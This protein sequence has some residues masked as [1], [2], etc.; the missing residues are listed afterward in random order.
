MARGLTAA[1]KALLATRVR[2]PAYFVDLVLTSGTVRVWNGVGDTTVLGNT[3]KGVG[4][5]G[6]IDGIEQDRS[7]KSTSVTL[8]LVGVPGTYITSGVIAATRAVRYQGAALTIYLGFCN[9]DTGI[10]LADP[11]AIWTGFADVMTFSLGATIS[12][13]LTAEHFTSHLTR[14]NGLTMT[15]VNHNKRLGSPSPQDLFF[16]G[17]NRL[18]NVAR[19]VLT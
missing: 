7:L 19:P 17:T 6:I 5:H 8:A 15:T 13:S 10:P 14:T 2:A 16:E 1:Q 4:E 3:Y 9:V 18:M 12:C 11:T